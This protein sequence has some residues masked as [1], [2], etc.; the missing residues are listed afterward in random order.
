[1]LFITYQVNK[2][3]YLS[4][5][6]KYSE[7]YPS[8]IMRRRSISSRVRSILHMILLSIARQEK[9]I[10][11]TSIDKDMRG[12]LTVYEA[13]QLACGALDANKASVGPPPPPRSEVLLTFTGQSRCESVFSFNRCLGE[14]RCVNLSSV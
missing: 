11:I 8:H 9:E 12:W 5:L 3:N 6:T 7:L 2:Y 14:L 4:A 10:D 1:M 13:M